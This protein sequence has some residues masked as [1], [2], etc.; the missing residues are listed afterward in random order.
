MVATTLLI[1][2]DGELLDDICEGYAEDSW[3]TCLLKVPFLPHGVQKVDGLLYA[4]DRLIVPRKST[5]HESLFHLAHDV[6]GHF[7]FMKS[8]GSLR[9]SFYW[10]N[11]QHNLEL[12][13]VPSCADCQWNKP[14]TKRLMGP[15]HPLLIPD[16][17]GNS[18][19]IDFIGPLLE[20]DDDARPG[21]LKQNP[22][23][24]FV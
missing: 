15:L 14:T 11:M 21:K 5:V 4:R 1:S 20:D 19:A 7:G 18:V 22:Y 24:G 13:Y 16:Q 8:Y 3:C 9:D 12:A 2:A 6:L 10:P 23:I 17:C